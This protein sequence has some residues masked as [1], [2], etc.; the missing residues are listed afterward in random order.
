M[1]NQKLNLEIKQLWC[2]SLRSGK[3]PQGKNALNRSGT[4]CCLGVLPDLAVRAGISKRTEENLYLRPEYNAKDDGCNFIN[5]SRTQC[6]RSC[7]IEDVRVWV[8]LEN[9]D[10]CVVTTKHHWESIGVKEPVSL[11]YKVSQLNDR[12]FSFETI[13]SLIEEQL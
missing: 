11:R 1:T 3:Y 7:L 12:G 10:P 6:S 13:A 5:K 2:S 9:L 8:G 4:F